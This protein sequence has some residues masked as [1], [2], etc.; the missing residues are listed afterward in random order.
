MIT[1]QLGDIPFGLE[2]AGAE[3]ERSWTYER[4]SVIEGRPRLQWV[5]DEL[6]SR[7]LEI[8]LHRSFGDPQQSCDRLEAA[9]DQHQALPLV[10]GGVRRGDF[11][12]EKLAESARHMDAEGR[13][14]LV[15]VRLTLTEYAPADPLLVVRLQAREAARRAR[16]EA[17]QEAEPCQSFAD[18]FGEEELYPQSV[19]PPAA[20][21]PGLGDLWAAVFGEDVPDMPAEVP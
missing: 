13:L 3:R 4:Q 9:A 14:E 7:T 12:I 16:A 5:A 21:E 8:L 10:I 11:V 2:L 19:L 1:A 15:E 6:E 17:Q 20:V 18:Q